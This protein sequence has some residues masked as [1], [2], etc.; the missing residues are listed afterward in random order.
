L[1]PTLEEALAGAIV[2]ATKA[3]DFDLVRELL[4]KI[5]TLPEPTSNV[6]PMRKRGAK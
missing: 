1:A 6:I 2:A 5:E 3:G 4:T